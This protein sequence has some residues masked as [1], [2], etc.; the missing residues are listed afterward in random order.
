MAEVPLPEATETEHCQ[1]SA[2]QR[3]RPARVTIAEVVEPQAADNKSHVA[4]TEAKAAT[5]A[6]LTAGSLQTVKVGVAP[7]ITKG[8]TVEPFAGLSWLKLLGTATAPGTTEEAAS[9]A[10]AAAEPRT[11][12]ASLAEEGTDRVLA[13]SSVLLG[14][15]AATASSYEVRT[16]DRPPAV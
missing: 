14:K 13:E 2:L 1:G 15:V 9:F 3:D 8:M 4:L 6:S 12:S 5:E 7:F 16:V 11:D 10:F